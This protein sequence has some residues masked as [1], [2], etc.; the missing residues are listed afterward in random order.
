[1]IANVRM[2]YPRVETA[3]AATYPWVGKARPMSP[4]A[5]ANAAAQLGCEV[6]AIQAIAEVES[7][8]GGF[9]S[10]GS[11][12]RRFEPH[13]MPGATMNWRASM[14]LSWAERERLFAEAVRRDPEAALR[15]T[16]FGRFQIM[17][18][19][20]TA[21]GFLSAT[22]MVRKMADS[23]DA[24][25][26]G[27]VRLLQSWG[28]TGAV[29][30]HDWTAFAR[31]YNGSGQVAEYAR[32]MEAAYRRRAGGKASPVVLRVGD[33]G[34]AVKRLQTALG[35]TPDGAFGPSTLDAVKDF[36]RRADLA[37]DGIVGAVTWA[38]I[39]ADVPTIRPLMQDVPL[40]AIAATAT[41]AGTAAAAVSAAATALIQ[42]SEALPDSVEPFI[43]GALG[44]IALGGGGAAIYR[45]ARG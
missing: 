37:V 30:A 31:R 25:V 18:F 8:G 1:M 12:E 29:R 16:S 21:A 33:R 20:A 10:D 9:R 19:N 7:A 45:W 41:K 40:D 38:K 23:E 35:V 6:A 22:E 11:L 24:Q 32:R 2:S 3:M 13:H 39:V 14:A 42:I 28:L 15:A 26:E 17:G 27:F 36:Q 5:F 43:W 44:L 4:D 34:E